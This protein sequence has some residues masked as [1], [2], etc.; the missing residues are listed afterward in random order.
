MKTQTYSL[1]LALVFV[2]ALTALAALAGAQDILPSRD[3]SPASAYTVLYS[4]CPTGL[5][6]PDGE[7]PYGGLVRDNSGNLDG[8]TSS[9]G[10][11]DSGSV[12]KVDPSG[13]ETVLYSFS[14]GNDGYTPNGVTL[15]DGVLLRHYA[16]RRELW[17]RHGVLV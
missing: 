7:S 5:P 16:V 12:F 4:F 9:G 3:S 6:C 11:Y 14:G 15:A 10:L 2:V 8:T 1:V 17:E 13:H